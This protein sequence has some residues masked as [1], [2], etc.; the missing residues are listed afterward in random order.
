MDIFVRNLPANATNKQVNTFFAP[1]FESFGIRD[2]YCE[3]YIGKNLANIT[4]L[5]AGAA[6]RFL[7]FYGVPTNAPRGVSPRNGLRWSGKL[8]WC[9]QNR[10]D[11]SD[12]SL[13]AVAFAASEK[14]RK[15]VHTTEIQ[16][17]R[18][19]ANITRF[20]ISSVQCGQLDYC[21]NRLCFTTQFSLVQQGTI[22][23]GRKE[24]VIVLGGEDSKQRRIYLNYADCVS[25]ILGQYEDPALTFSLRNPPKFYEVE[26]A[27]DEISN[28]LLAFALNSAPAKRASAK[29]IRIT[30]IDG[31]HA[32]VSGMCLVYRFSL[33]DHRMISTVR[34]LLSRNVK[35]PPQTV[36]STPVVY[37]TQSIVD[38]YTRLNYYLTDQGYYGRQPFAMLYQL[39]RLARNGVLPPQK[40]VDLL[41]TVARIHATHGLDAVLSA[42][43]KFYLRVRFAGPDTD[44]SEVSHSALQVLLEE[45][46]S[47]YDRY[48]Y[49][50]KNPYELTKR[51]THINL[52]H[53]IIVTPCGIY[54]HGLEPE[55]TNRVLRRYESY[56]NDFARVVFQDE[57]GNSVRYD[58][59]ANQDIIYHSRF[60]GVLDGGI[61]IAGRAFSFLGFSHSSLRSQSCW[62]MAPIFADG[63]F[64]LP[65]HILK[66]LGDF[67]NI[68]IPAKCAARIGQNFTDT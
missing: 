56:I 66:E 42:L 32:K 29:K 18:Q 33:L 20:A 6:Q 21:G 34:S 51:H 43:R 15:A 49:N 44:A 7:D 17:Y 5:D 41:P 53:K 68:R 9:S 4:V 23:L 45:F 63:N 36:M 27:E 46:A 10:Q 2:Y 11:V 52:V 60:K 12:F 31:S 8:I 13:Q 14:A 19:N 62:F 64:K 50:P 40:V 30:G 22:S 35:A 1:V 59:R 48:K 55:P 24:A 57:D 54:L 26:G 39:D 38:I 47:T 67:A 25:V 3:K 37:P 61:I 65:S 16:K 58:P 28:A